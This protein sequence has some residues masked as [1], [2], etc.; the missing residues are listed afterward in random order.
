VPIVA[1]TANAMRG[2]DELCFAAGMNGYITK[3]ISAAS[4]LGAV[5]RYARLQQA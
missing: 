3:P 4:L 2:D 5:D 1:I